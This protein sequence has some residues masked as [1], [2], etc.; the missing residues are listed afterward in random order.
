MF[1]WQPISLAPKGPAGKGIYILGYVP[2]EF[3]DPKAN[4]MVIWWEENDQAWFSDY[5]CE[6]GI[7]PSHWMQLP[8]PP[9]GC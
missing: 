5:E 6:K 2:G 4:I 1:E 9:E 7:R 8:E 3:N